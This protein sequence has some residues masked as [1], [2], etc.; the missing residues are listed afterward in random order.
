MN[1]LKKMS[2]L[3]LST[4]LTITLSGCLGNDPELAV[5][6]YNPDPVNTS[7]SSSGNT[8]NNDKDTSVVTDNG[9]DDNTVVTDNGNDNN[10]L[11]TDIASPVAVQSGEAVLYN[12]QI[13]FREYNSFQIEYDAV[14]GDFPRDSVTY[15]EKGSLC[16]FDPS[17]PEKGASEIVEDT[18]FGDMYLINGEELYSQYYTSSEDYSRDFNM[19]Y[20]TNL[21]TLETEDVCEGIIAGFSPD[22]KYFAVNNYETDPYLTHFYIYDTADLSKP[23]ADFSS[24]TGMVYLGMDN[25]NL[26]IM[27]NNSDLET[28]NI[29]QLGNDGSIYT[30]ANCNFNSLNEEYTYLYPEY[31]DAISMDDKSISLRFDF[32]D[33]TGHFYTTSADVT[34]PKAVNEQPSEKPLFEA[35]IKESPMDDDPNGSLPSTIASFESYP[36]YESGRGFARVIQYYNTFDEGTFF[37]IADCHRNPFEDVGWRESYYFL[38]L[39]YCFIPAGSK[40]F[41]VVDKMFDLLGERGNL[42]HYESDEIMNTMFVYAGFFYDENKELVGIYYEPVYI[43]GV[44]SPIEESGYT[45]IADLSEDFYYESFNW[46][47]DMYEDDFLQITDKTALANELNLLTES[48]VKAAEYDYEGFLVFGPDDYSFTSTQAYICHIGWDSDGNVY[49]VRPVLFD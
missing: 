14:W 21:K 11:D 13:L 42:S 41:T 30:L 16:T 20:K 24:D 27:V 43:E 48:P 29:I 47:E 17:D 5:N 7:S 39:E 36:D 8:D 9:T 2:V 35:D 15:G 23:S 3:L 22:G 34:V 32:Y 28:Y 6:L 37:A 49:Y 25:D 19:V 45:Y 4:I 33:G 44:E 40:E 12:G 18:G 1:K 46:E 26:Y 38:N 31:Y 10:T